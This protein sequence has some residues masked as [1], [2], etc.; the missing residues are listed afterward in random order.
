MS[1]LRVRVGQGLP[2]DRTH[3]L[4]EKTS[5]LGSTYL[6]TTLGHL[7]CGPAQDGYQGSEDTRHKASPETHLPEHWD[8]CVPSESMTFL[9][10]ISRN[11]NHTKTKLCFIQNIFFSWL[12]VIPVF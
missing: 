8:S 1:K 12:T 11:A 7:R 2:E 4:L 5:S 6:L 9:V 3:L 10:I